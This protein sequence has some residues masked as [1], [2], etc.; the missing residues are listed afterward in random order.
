MNHC[1]L[2]LFWYLCCVF[3]SVQ[4][5]CVLCLPMA[6]VTPILWGLLFAIHSRHPSGIGG[7]CE[8]M[9]VGPVGHLDGWWW[10]PW[11]YSK[12]RC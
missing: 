4:G 3:G 2:P 8:R 7:D 10:W 9:A 1:F 6:E 5:H 12:W 11:W